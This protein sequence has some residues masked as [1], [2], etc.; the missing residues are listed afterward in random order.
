M[1]AA[2]AREHG[3][4]AA[5]TVAPEIMTHADAMARGFPNP[6]VVGALLLAAPVI[7]ALTIAF[8][9]R[10][11]GLQAA[12]GGFIVVAYFTLS[13]QV[14]ENHFYLALPLLAIAAALRPAFTPVLAA[15]SVT[16]ALNLF[17]PFGFK[18]SGPPPMVTA[19]AGVDTGVAVAVVTC[20]SFAWF[21]VILARACATAMPPE[22]L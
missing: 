18:G 7:W 14:H 3:I 15:L 12:L 22:R 9:A 11:L 20:A 4:A 21:A 16:F 6:R 2:A 13:V 1:T 17:L 10:D 5:L 19:I 8:R